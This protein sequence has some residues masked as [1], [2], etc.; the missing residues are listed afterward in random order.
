M[1]VKNEIRRE[2][3]V[4]DIIEKSFND[5]KKRSIVGQEWLEQLWNEHQSKKHNNTSLLTHIA[6][7]EFIL[8]TFKVNC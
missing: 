4:K 5:I 3:P 8:K 2:S 6:S 1:D 7:L